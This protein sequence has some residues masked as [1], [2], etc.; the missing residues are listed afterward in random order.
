MIECSEG[1]EEEEEESSPI[2]FIQLLCTC[3]TR[4]IDHDEANQD[5]N[6]LLFNI[7]TKT[8]ERGRRPKKLLNSKCREINSKSIPFFFL[9]FQFKSRDSGISMFKNHD[10]EATTTSTTDQYGNGI[11]SATTLLNH[12]NNNCKNGDALTEANGTKTVPYATGTNG[13]IITMTLKNNHLIV[14]TEER[15]VSDNYLFLYH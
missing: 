14:E 7:T 11:V 15:N 12:H 2:K 13:S 3:F 4:E 10:L 9:C 1:R 5:G 6:N 8:K